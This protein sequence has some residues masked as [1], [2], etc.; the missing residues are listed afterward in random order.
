M[1]ASRRNVSR[2]P[3]PQEVTPSLLSSCQTRTASGAGYEPLIYFGTEECLQSERSLRAVRRQKLRDFLASLRALNRDHREIGALEDFDSEILGV[4]A[5]PCEIL[6]A[7]A[8]IHDHAEPRLIHEIDDEIVDDAAG[9]VEHAAVESFARLS[10]LG[11]VVGKQASQKS[12]DLSAFEIDDAHVRDIENAGC[13]PHGMVL[14]DLRGV[15][16]WHVPAAEVDDACAELP[17]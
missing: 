4:T 11:N 13:A 6:V 2:A 16:H 12:A 17:M 8:G 3:R 5:G 7:R 9:L 1:P 10:E 14:L 15:L